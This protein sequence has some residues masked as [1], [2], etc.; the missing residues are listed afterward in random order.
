M[1]VFALTLSLGLL[2]VA[3][4]DDEADTTPGTGTGGQVSVITK[5][6]GNAYRG[7]LFEYVRSDK[8]DARNYFDAIRATDGSIQSAGP[9]S[10]L[11][12][13]QFGGSIGGPL[14]KNRAF[15]FGSYEEFKSTKSNPSAGPVGSS[16]GTVVLK[17]SS[18]ITRAQCGPL[19]SFA[20]Q[21]SCVR[22]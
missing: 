11:K 14:R 19:D 13:N 1:R 12:Q 9:K 6:G 7:S 20:P 16:A 21:V 2:T 3:C 5:S 18:S 4:G 17:S 8:M 22:L 15:F 10:S